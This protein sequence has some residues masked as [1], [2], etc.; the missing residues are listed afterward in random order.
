MAFRMNENVS[1]LVACPTII[2]FHVLCVITTNNNIAREIIIRQ[3]K[4]E[5]YFKGDV[6]YYYS[7][8]RFL[9]YPPFKL[10]ESTKDGTTATMSQHD[11]ANF[12][13]EKRKSYFV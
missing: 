11:L 3:R 12:R 9:W 7:T 10:D 8:K 1:P 6:N 13:F 4:T 5:K 2:I